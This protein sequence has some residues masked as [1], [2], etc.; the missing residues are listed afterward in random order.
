MRRSGQGGL[1]APEAK[2][3]GGRRIFA[4]YAREDDGIVRRV[5][6]F[7]ASVGDRYLRD[8]T[9]LRAGEE[10]NPGLARTGFVRPSTGRTRSHQSPPESADLKKR[11]R[12]VEGA[13]AP[14]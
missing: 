1:V 6:A 12:S 7:A 10:W 11:I 2:R 5:S 8:V 4:S 9:S 3:P 14:S 13:S